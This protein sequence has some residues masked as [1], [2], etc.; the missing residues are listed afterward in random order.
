MLEITWEDDPS[1]WTSWMYFFDRI[2]QKC[3]WHFS[4]YLAPQTEY[5]KKTKIICFS[6]TFLE[7]YIKQPLQPR[8]RKDLSRGFLTFLFQKFNKVCVNVVPGT[9]YLHCA[10]HQWHNEPQASS[11]RLCLIWQKCY[12]VLVFFLMGL[13]VLLCVR[14]LLFSIKACLWCFLFIHTIMFGFN[15]SVD[16]DHYIVSG[17]RRS[18]GNQ[19]Q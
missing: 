7:K 5:W 10:C 8:I 18:L 12:H 4:T 9:G 19:G 15:C 14:P 6:F 16:W 13:F 1:R 11:K 17:V 2:A 3:P